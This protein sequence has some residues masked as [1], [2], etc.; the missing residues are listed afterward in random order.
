MAI[1]RPQLNAMENQI[2]NSFLERELGLPRNLVPEVIPYYQTERLVKGEMMTSEGALC[3]KMYLIEE[4]Y[5]RFY[6]YSEKKE[7][8][9]WIFG[10]GQLVTDVNSFFFRTA[11]KWNIQALTETRVFSLNYETHQELRTKLAPFDQYEKHFIIKLLGALENRVYTLLSM[12]AQERYH[13]LL[14]ADPNLFT[15]LPLQFLASML[16]MTPETL[17]RIRARSNS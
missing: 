7:V 16:G 9:H 11:S 13:Y 8:T 14:E 4:G 15:V 5:V 12:S 2:L 1:Y 6:S 10:K 3:H 17:S